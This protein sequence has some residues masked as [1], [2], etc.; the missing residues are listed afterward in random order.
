MSD[1]DPEFEGRPHDDRP[2]FGERRRRVLRITVLVALAALVLPLVLSV[3]GQAQSA[4]ARACAV[5]VER[6]DA[7]AVGSRVALDLFADGG[8]GWTCSAV[9][10]GGVETPLAN[11]GLLPSAPQ[12]VGPDEI[13]A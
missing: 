8:P 9:S 13:P 5:Y 3:A 6:F 4:A 11:L 10:E 12:P 1:S 2:V 7:D